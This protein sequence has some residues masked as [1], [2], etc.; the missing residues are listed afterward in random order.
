MTREKQIGSAE[1]VCPVCLNKISAKKIYRHETIFL[2]KSCPEHGF[3]SV[4]IWEGSPESY[5]AWDRKNPVKDSLIAPKPVH[6]GC[7]FDCGLCAN[8]LRK[9]C[10]VLLEV[11]SDCNLKCPV[12]FAGAG[13]SCVDEP[14]LEVLDALYKRLM[15]SGGPYNIQLSGG[16]PTL[17]DDLP[18][19]ISLGI[20][21]G[22]NFF[23][24]NTNGLRLADDPDYLQALIDA[25][26]N[27]V[28]LQFDGFRDRTWKALRGASLLEVKQ[29]SIDNC[30]KL[31]IGVVL[32]PTVIKGINDDELGDIIAFAEANM[33]YIRGVHFQP[34]SQ[35]GRFAV[36]GTPERI[37][38]PGFLRA[39]ESQ[40]D[41][42]LKADDFIA[43]GAENS[44]CSFHCSYLVDQG[45]YK[46]LTNASVGCCSTSSDT[47]REAVARQWTLDADLHCDDTTDTA[48]CCVSEPASCCTPKKTDCTS[49]SHAANN[50]SAPEEQKSDEVKPCCAP[51]AESCCGDSQSTSSAL[52]TADSLDAFLREREQK[53]LAISGMLFQDA[54]TLEIDRLKS[55]YICEA[56]DD[57]LIPFC[58]YNLTDSKGVYLYRSMT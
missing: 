2:E 4:P 8:H 15:T 56:T 30:R 46:P 37:T 12:C 55:C 20:K 57:G 1:S 5:A 23:Q 9:T 36:E 14:S 28:Y 42:N 48:N 38:L 54:Y 18:Q 3:F 13:K 19:I 34:A 27:T 7:P 6:K 10:C 26:L 16:E 41:G 45:A 58:A 43:G 39:L 21:H 17:R 29:R 53:T 51:K 33:P 24:L 50:S 49:A 40:T 47:S 32:V 31:G 44:Y 11:T 22:F 35:F 52:Y 25:G